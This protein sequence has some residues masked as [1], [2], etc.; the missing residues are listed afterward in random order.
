[1]LHSQRHARLEQVGFKGGVVLSA[2]C[3]GGWDLDWIEQTLGPLKR[4]IG[5]EYYSP[6]PAELPENVEWIKNTVGNMEDVPSDS[7]D[8][9]FSGQNLEHLW[10]EEMVGFLCEANRVLRRGGQLVIDSFGRS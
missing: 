10:V 1:M 8:L 6:R 4:H 5:V 2:G 3:S 7:V 9:V